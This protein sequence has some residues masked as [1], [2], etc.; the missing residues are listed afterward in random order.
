M[1]TRKYLSIRYLKTKNAEG[2]VPETVIL[3]SLN[4]QLVQN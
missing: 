4:V 3:L 1:H 2:E